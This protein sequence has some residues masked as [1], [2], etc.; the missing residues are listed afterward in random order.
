MI[1]MQKKVILY[2]E[3]PIKYMTT[4]MGYYLV[5][6]GIITFSSRCLYS[7]KL[8]ILPNLLTAKG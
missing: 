6:E 8:M 7:R 5:E 1:T 2:A 3:K 4:V